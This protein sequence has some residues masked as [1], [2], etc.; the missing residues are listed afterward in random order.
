V[1]GGFFG[2]G[3]RDQ[4]A[5]AAQ[6]LGCTEGLRAEDVLQRFTEGGAAA[7]VGAESGG[8]VGLGGGMGTEPA[9]LKDCVGEGAGCFQEQREEGGDAVCAAKE[10]VRESR[11]GGGGDTSWLVGI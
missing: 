7:D 3:A 8:G 1:G 6:D 5:P 2:F 10:G 4:D 11:H 9:Q